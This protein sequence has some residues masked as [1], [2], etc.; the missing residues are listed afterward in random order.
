MFGIIKSFWR[1]TTEYNISIHLKALL[2][3]VRLLYS[4]YSTILTQFRLPK[5]FGTQPEQ[6]RSFSQFPSVRKRYS[7]LPGIIERVNFHIPFL[8]FFRGF[9]FLSQLLNSPAKK[10]SLASGAENSNGT[11]LG[12]AFFSPASLFANMSSTS[13]LYW[14]CVT[15][16]LDIPNFFLS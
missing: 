8:S 12:V 13:S 2:R 9:A 14:Q 3:K 16:S 7:Y 5:L 15:S 1:K 11:F 10:T 6:E 4:T